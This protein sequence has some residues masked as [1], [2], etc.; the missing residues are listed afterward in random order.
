MSS[1]T[2]PSFPMRSFIIQRPFSLRVKT[3]CG[4]T[5]F[6]SLSRPTFAG[7]NKWSK[8]KDKKGANDACRSIVYNKATLDIVNAAKVGGSADPEKNVSLA[9]VLKRVKAQNVPKENIAKA[10]A[11]A[12]KAK[13]SGETTVYEA[14]ACNSVGIIIECS[15]NNANRTVQTLREILAVR[16]AR[17][18]PVGFMFQR[19]GLV[20]VSLEKNSQFDEM[21][22]KTVVIA[23]DNGSEDF[24]TSPPGETH[25]EIEFTCDPSTL[26]S[27]TTALAESKLCQVL[28]SELTYRPITS[29]EISDEESERVNELVKALAA[30]DDTM[31]VWTNMPVSK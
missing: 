28:A 30:H 11:K 26:S 19:N 16:G 13:G 14:I 8:I 9:A 7:H 21:L 1:T 15:T 4:T 12:D 25:E 18:A 3:L 31:R 10:L 5:R 2:C 17:I 27:L 22:E 6:F 29:A 23:V 24:E 20:K